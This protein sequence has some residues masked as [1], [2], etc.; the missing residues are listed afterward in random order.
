MG[1]RVR[2]TLALAPSLREGLGNAVSLS[3]RRA[4]WKYCALVLFPHPEGEG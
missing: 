1:F 2:N 3:S 4:D